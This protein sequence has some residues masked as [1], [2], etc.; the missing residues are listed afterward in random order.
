MII[1]IDTEKVCDKIS[2][3]FMIL[4]QVRGGNY[5]EKGTFKKLQGE[6]NFL[7]LIKGIYKNPTANIKLNNERLNIF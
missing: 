5:E 6:G 2:H 3:T 7:H 4:R 1:S